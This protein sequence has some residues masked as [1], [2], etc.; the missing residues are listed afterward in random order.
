MDPLGPARHERFERPASLMPGFSGLRFYTFP[1]GC[2]TYEFH[3]LPGAS[4]VLAVAI[5]SA[6]A[7]QAP[8]L[9]RPLRMA[10]REPLSC[11]AAAPHAPDECPSQRRCTS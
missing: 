1:G 7:F 2:V 3:H 4:P 8:L 9:P 11:A 6:L 5:D 10:D